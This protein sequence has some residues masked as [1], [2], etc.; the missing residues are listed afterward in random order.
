M[1]VNVT[2]EGLFYTVPQTVSTVGREST[3]DTSWLLQ[4]ETFLGNP[5]NAG[6]DKK[7]HKNWFSLPTSLV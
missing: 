7:H 3:S 2:G 4:W 6:K 5:V 1:Y